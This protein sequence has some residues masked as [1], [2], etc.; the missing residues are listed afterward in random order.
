M[1]RPD[2]VLPAAVDAAPLPQVI[3][4]TQWPSQYFQHVDSFGEIFHVMVSR[5]SYNLR[6]MKVDGQALPVPQ[7]L[8]AQDQV[9]LCEA[10]EYVGAPNESSAWQ[11]SDYAPY[12]PQCDVLL[13]HAYAHAPDGK[14]LRT[15]PVA[16]RVGDALEKKIQ[17]TGPRRFERSITSLGT[18]SASDPEPATVVPLVYELAFGG[19]NTIANRLA[20]EALQANPSLNAEQRRHIDKALAQCPAYDDFNPI[21]CG[22]NAG[23]LTDTA[24]ALVDAQ[25]GGAPAAALRQR[26]AEID[27]I[28]RP[29]PQIEAYGQPWRR[30]EGAGDYPVV[31]VGPVGRWWQ[32]RRE[33]AGTHDAAWKATQ[34]PKSPKDH[35]YAYW[36]CAPKDQQIPFPQG[37]EEVVLVNLTPVGSPVRF[38]L[39][40]QDLRL[41]VRLNA[42]PML[43]APMNIDTVVIDFA[44]GTL[45][46]VRR[47]LM[48]AR[49]DV[50]QLELG[51]WPAG[52]GPDLS[53]YGAEQGG[54][55]APAKGAPRHG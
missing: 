43:F 48:A 42:G 28:V 30:Q 5:I 53:E 19:P 50:R 41:L 32:P 49:A 16:F 45:S 24:R 37:G 8:L 31:G 25:L 38:A 23:A 4:H 15:W 54:S 17:V 26:E 35:N 11:E 40:T 12:K 46:L 47:A 3:N 36:N 14:A 39:P 9:P 34:W 33:L 52:T 18:L 10:D 6:N 1:D 7:I 51:T 21:G 29:A 55:K 2:H 27:A 22:R 20:L 44:S 13:A